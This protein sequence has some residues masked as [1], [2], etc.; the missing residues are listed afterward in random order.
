MT[1]AYG[2]LAN[3]GIYREPFM[4]RRVEDPFG[5]VL[6]QHVQKQTQVLDPALVYQ[7][8]DMM[9]S[10]MDQGTGRSVRKKGF[11]RIAAG[12]TGTTNNFVDSWFSGFTP[13]IC[14]CVWVGF[15]KPAPL[16][17]VNKR[18]ITGARGAA[19]IWG[20]FMSRAL[21][22]TPERDFPRPPHVCFARVNPVTGCT[23]SP[24]TEKMESPMNQMPPM[25][26]VLKTGQKVCQT[27]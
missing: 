6:F 8:V 20:D 4:I 25:S 10:V 12:K 13:G 26:I 9:K 23:I 2:V 1:A 16:W 11:T 14:A 27:P 18:G 17:D 19:P 7:I 24:D 5:R 3:M 21:E 22:Q 15:D